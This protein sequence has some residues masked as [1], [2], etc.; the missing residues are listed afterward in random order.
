M[1]L[2]SRDMLL[3]E[4][5]LESLGWRQ[6]AVNVYEKPSGEMIEIYLG[7]PRVAQIYIE[8]KKLPFW[9]IMRC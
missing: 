9:G 1:S 2:F 6:R 4:C 8:K 7:A 5:P 3:L